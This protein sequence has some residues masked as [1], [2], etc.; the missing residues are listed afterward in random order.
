MNKILFVCAVLSFPVLANAQK[1]TGPKQSAQQSLKK[2]I[3]A[4]ETKIKELE[5]N[6]KKL[7][8]NTLETMIQNKQ[9]KV[10]QLQKEIKSLEQKECAQNN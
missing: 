1:V 8:A 7:R 10:D 6:I 4:N 9:K 5:E 3:K 2:T